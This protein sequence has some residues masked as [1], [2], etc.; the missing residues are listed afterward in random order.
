[1]SAISV[2]SH[3]PEQTA[4]LV[5]IGIFRPGVERCETLL[6]GAGAAAAVGDPVGAS[7]MPCHADEEWAIVPEIS[8]IGRAQ[9]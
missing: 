3:R 8:Q 9:V 7:A 2:V 1:M 6:A 4:R 5:E